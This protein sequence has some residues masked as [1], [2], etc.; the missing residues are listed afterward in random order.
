VY[1]ERDA[2]N[3]SQVW[4]KLHRTARPWFRFDPVLG[5]ICIKAQGNS[6]TLDIDTLKREALEL[7]SPID[8]GDKA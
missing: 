5:V 1:L 8:S 6:E 3:P 2:N 7:V 4:V